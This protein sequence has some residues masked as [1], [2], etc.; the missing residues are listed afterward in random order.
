MAAGP[1]STPP[2]DER[3]L[4]VAPSGVSALVSS[5]GAT[6]VALHAPDRAGRF[7]DV[8]LGFDTATEY[9][10]HANLYAGATIGRVAG[11]IRDARFPLG[12]SMVELTAN[13]GPHQLH[14]TSRTTRTG[15]WP[16]P[17]PPP[18]STTGCSWRP[19][20]ARPPTP[21]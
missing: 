4:L 14:A 11:R 2:G 21:R 13:D 18:S 8:V 1:L 9:A 6:L 12:G 3:H 7:D 15:T 17:A 19:T 10:A 20:A 16:G 5:W